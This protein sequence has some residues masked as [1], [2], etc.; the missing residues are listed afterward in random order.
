MLENE[1]EKGV[2]MKQS[3]CAFLRILMDYNIKSYIIPSVYLIADRG[4]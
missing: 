1:K 3:Q 2:K 4:V